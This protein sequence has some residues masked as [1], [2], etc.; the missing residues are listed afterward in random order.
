ME[1]LE[2]YPETDPQ[3]RHLSHLY[4]L[5]PAALITPE[6]NPELAEACRKSLNI[7]GDD[8]PGWS[9]AYKILFWARLKDGNRAYKLFRELLKPTS[10]T[11]IN[12]GGGGGSYANLFSAGPPFQIDGN[13]GG[14][15]GIAEMLLQSH[16]EFIELLPALPNAWKS[17]G[18][19]KGL[20]ARGNVT[21]DFEWQ[22]GKV[23]SVQ[24]FAEEE[25]TIWVKVNGEL[26]AIKTSRG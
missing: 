24:V 3:H 2:E 13:F 20:R 4:G 21:V 5:F 7:R 15:A 19:I 22:D 6:K 26:K 1:W 16:Q 12:Y 18:K 23:V 14:T 11:H 17:F 9:K 8:S 10:E 25:K